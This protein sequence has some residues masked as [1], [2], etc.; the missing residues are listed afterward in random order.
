MACEDS[1]LTA[2][3]KPGVLKMD[4]LRDD[5]GPLRSQDIFLN[6]AGRSFG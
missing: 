4:L 2:A 6:L 1:G 3:L 5:R